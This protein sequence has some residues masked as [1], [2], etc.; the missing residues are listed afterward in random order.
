MIK[1]R[2]SVIV[3]VYNAQTTLARC[4][5]SIRQQSFTH[6]EVC[7]VNDG[8]KDNSL[9][10]CKRYASEDARFRV[11]DQE[12]GGVSS[13]RNTGLAAATGQFITFIDADDAIAPG[14]FEMLM[15]HCHF[16]LVLCSS[17]THPGNKVLLFPEQTFS[18]TS[19][20][21]LGLK[22]YMRVGFTTPWGKLFRTEII[23]KQGLTFDNSLSV[24]EDTLFVNQYLTHISSLRFLSYAGYIYTVGDSTHLSRKAI[25][26]PYLIQS[27]EKILPSYVALETKYGVNLGWYKHD[28]I[29]FFLHRC[30]PSASTGGIRHTVQELKTLCEYPLINHTFYENRG[31]TK[32][33][34]QKV[35]D[36]LARHKQYFWLALLTKTAGKAYF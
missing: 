33:R 1:C 30:L 6:F 27:L 25:S 19:A 5:D 7:L 15:K 35:F 28:L 2:L 29:Q 34:L 20:I 36:Y 26:Y 13:A 22:K 23:K 10:L 17:I 11:I 9:D 4:L 21:A 3:P 18:Q 14:Y 32:G 31:G 16:D 8:S 12:N 24:G